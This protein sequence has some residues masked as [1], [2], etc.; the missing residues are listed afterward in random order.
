MC[1]HALQSEPQPGGCRGYQHDHSYISAFDLRSQQD[2]SQHT[3]DAAHHIDER[4][5]YIRASQCLT[6]GFHIK[7]YGI[8]DDTHGEHGNQE[9]ADYDLPP[10][11]IL[12]FCL[13]HKSI[14][15]RDERLMA[16]CVSAVDG[17]AYSCDIFGFI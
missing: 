5:L 8:A 9:T 4:K 16:G 17:N 2:G 11:E 14:L 6:Y 1:S 15:P 10:I 13:C 3:G 12:S 7:G